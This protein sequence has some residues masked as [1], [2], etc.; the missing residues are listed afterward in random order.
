MLLSCDFAAVAAVAT[1]A[2]VVEAVYVFL[3]AAAAAAAAATVAVVVAQRVT[4]DDPNT[5]IFLGWLLAR[6]VCAALGLRDD[7]F[8]REVP[9]G[10]LG[11][12]DIPREVP[13]PQRSASRAR[14]AGAPRRRA[15]TQPNARGPGARPA[16]GRRGSSRAH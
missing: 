14:T 16:A 15:P 1:A 6:L 13:P 2:A 7:S 9:Y 10:L 8:L 4:R 3:D 11:L 12:A 5:L